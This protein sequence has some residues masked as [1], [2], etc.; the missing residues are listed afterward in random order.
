M[1]RFRRSRRDLKRAA[2]EIRALVHAFALLW[3]LLL[4]GPEASGAEDQWQAAIDT[5]VAGDAAHP[6]PRD[7]VVFV[8]SSSIRLWTTLAQDFPGVPVVNRGFGGSMIADSTRHVAQLIVP[9]RPKLVVLYAGDNDVDGGHTAD[10]VFDD[11]KAFVARVRRDLP[12]TAI[13]FVSIKP[14]LARA[15]QWP[16]MREANALVAQWAATQTDVVYVDT[17][18]AM[19]GADG[20]PRRELLREDGLHLSASG[21]ALWTERLRPVLARYGFRADRLQ[22]GAL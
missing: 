22:G 21:Y 19:L 11:F 12:E 5:L 17:A 16:T 6:P 9:Y 2:T 14:S 1:R 13:A 10:Q 3:L 4:A 20:K 15:A 7:G 18:S 8:G